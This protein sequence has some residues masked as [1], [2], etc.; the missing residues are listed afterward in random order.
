MT[1][2]EKETDR[3]PDNQTAQTE[4]AEAATTLEALRRREVDAVIGDG[5]VLLLRLQE[6]EEALRTS[7]NNLRE[8]NKTLEERV[9]ERTLRL[10]QQAQRLRQLATEL[11]DIEQRE[12]QRLSKLLHDGLQQI[13]IGIEFQL[14]MAIRDGDSGALQQAKLLVAEAVQ[15]SRSLAYELAPPVLYELGFIDALQWLIRRFRENHGFEV[16]LKTVP[17]FAA[18]TESARVFLFHA[19]REL[20]LN[21]LKHSGVRN[22]EVHCS[23]K[24][25]QQLCIEVRDWGRGF[26][27]DTIS[28]NIDA[29]QGLGL[30]SIR[31]RLFAIGGEFEINAKPGEGS[32]FMLTFPLNASLAATDSSVR[33][34]AAAQVHPS[35]WQ[36]PAQ[37]AAEQVHRSREDAT[38]AADAA[39]PATSAVE[40]RAHG[41]IEDQEVEHRQGY[42]VRYPR[43]LIVDDHQIVREGLAALLKQAGFAIVGDS[44]DGVSAIELAIELR[45]DIVLMD[46]SLPSMD[47]VEATRQICQQLPNCKVVGI[48]WHEKADME[49]A[50]YDAGAQLYLQKETAPSSLIAA[51]LKLVQQPV[52]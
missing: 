39:T 27:A 47:G 34:T 42:F 22:A 38:T 44:G 12:R 37:H 33:G 46:V 4:Y 26:D 45:P 16:T 17:A 28:T 24:G 1:H 14:T 2:P 40:K 10:E 52:A 13:L 21:S 3:Q 9:A 15:T 49:Q 50:M 5:K 6:T 11:T 25:D 30:F 23:N 36:E 51:L 31:E 8:L 48:S 43:V 41:Q 29:E 20:L 32:H 19:V 35:T 18:V 7:E